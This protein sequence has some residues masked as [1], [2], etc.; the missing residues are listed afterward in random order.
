MYNVGF[1]GGKFCPFHKGH[2]N[3]ILRAASE[4]KKLYVVCMYNGPQELDIMWNQDI[5]FNKK[6]LTPHMRELVIRRELRDFPNIEVVMYNDLQAKERAKR[7]GKTTWE[8]ECE[9]MI[10][11]M[12]EFD[13]AY[14][15]EL[16]YH[17][18]FKESY[19][20][21]EAKMFDLERNDVPISATMIRSLPFVETYPLLPRSYQ[22]L[23]NK[24]VLITGTE[25]CGKSTLTKMLAKFF[26]TSYTEEYG[27][28]FC[29]KYKMTNPGLEWYEQF[30]HGQYM[31]EIKA[32]ET[33]NMV[34]FCDTDAAV[35][36]MYAKLYED[37]NLPMADMIAK[38][39]EWDL[40]LFV[41][42][43]NEWIADG[44]RQS[45]S[46]EERDRLNNL[47]KDMYEKEYGQQVK[48]LNGTYEENYMQA[49]QYV[50]DMLEM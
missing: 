30:L 3:C 47:L 32:K 41:E 20:F 44:L 35:T 17:E 15:S 24:S 16:E 50:K 45:G 2:L 14:S 36:N 37:T 13:V 11:L 28:T 27:R 39:K 10:K 31:E 29:E 34:Y 18:A 40:I 25:S 5:K 8:C 23:L 26:N 43:T 9:D 19:P 1:Y 38:N 46:Q 42:P 6:Y 49:V 7:E 33:A 21:A 48:V 4:C 12:G 22:R